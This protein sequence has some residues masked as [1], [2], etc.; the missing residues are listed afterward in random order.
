[1]TSITV[2]RNGSVEPN[3][4]QL[5]HGSLD[6]LDETGRHETTDITTFHEHVDRDATIGNQNCIVGGAAT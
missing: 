6:N 4:K 5:E 3:G 1:M 2:E